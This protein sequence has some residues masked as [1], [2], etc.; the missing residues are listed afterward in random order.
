MSIVD[1]SNQTILL[2]GSTGFLGKAL[3]ERLLYRFRSARVYILIRGSTA[4]K[5][6]VLQQSAIWM[7]TR[8]FTYVTPI[9]A[10][11]ELPGLGLSAIDRQTLSQ[12]PPTHVF[13]C[14]AAV[15]FDL[16]L[17]DSIRIN[18]YGTMHL[19]DFVVQ[20]AP[21]ARFIHVSTAYIGS[22]RE[23]ESIRLSEAEIREGLETG[24]IG[25][26]WPNTYV[27]S[28]AMCEYICVG[29]PNYNW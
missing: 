26:E 23:E 28:K 9:C 3:L 14:A 16:P 2:T 6:Q 22:T 25:A 4:E 8:D 15:T 12:Y 1:Y 24:T 18:V 7:R 19:Y 5:F 27:W 21:M 11:I 17:A 29:E 13:H 10:D 20:V